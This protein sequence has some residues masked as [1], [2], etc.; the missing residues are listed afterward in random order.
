MIA[1]KTL[2]E[3][4]YHRKYIFEKEAELGGNS[5][6]QAV[7]LG[8][9]TRWADMGVNDY[10]TKTYLNIYR[11][12]CELGA[13]TMPL[14]DTTSYSTSDGRVSYTVDGLPNTRQP[15]PDMSAAAYQQ[16]E[17]D[18]A[19]FWTSVYYVAID[20]FFEP[21]T[22]ADYLAQPYNPDNPDTP[23]YTYGAGFASH[24]LLPRINGMC[25]VPTAG[26]QQ[27]PIVLVTHY[28]VLQEGYNQ[29]GTPNPDRRYFVGGTR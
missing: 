23:A 11:L 15:Y 29:Y 24:Y 6:T 1:T 28:Y 13:V 18:I 20:P 21:K 12:I 25:F 22:V 10:N 9:D 17:Q 16:F 2:C 8:A 5:S 19:Y 7:Q 4:G 27:M 26:P 3:L 14:D